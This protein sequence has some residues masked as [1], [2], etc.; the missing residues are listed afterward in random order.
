MLFGVVSSSATCNPSN[1][2]LNLATLTPAAY[3]PYRTARVLDVNCWFEL[4]DT[5]TPEG[6]QHLKDIHEYFLASTEVKEFVKEADRGICPR[7]DN[8]TVYVFRT[9]EGKYIG[10]WNHDNNLHIGH[11]TYYSKRCN[12]SNVGWNGQPL[13]DAQSY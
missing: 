3:F 8:H 7:P 2:M 5:G 13:S 10:A 4:I 1:T 6:E 9:M 11:V 12:G